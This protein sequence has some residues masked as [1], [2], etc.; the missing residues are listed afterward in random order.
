MIQP[1]FPRCK[2]LSKRQKNVFSVGV[3]KNN[4]VKGLNFTRLFC[5]L[6][7]FNYFLGVEKGSIFTSPP[8]PVS[9]LKEQYTK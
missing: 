5:I 2:K 1:I 7:I 3:K 8:I 4:L 9:R 6:S